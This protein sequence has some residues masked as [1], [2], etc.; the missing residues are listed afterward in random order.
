MGILST[1][2]E[3]RASSYAGGHVSDHEAMR[4]VFSWT[5]TAAGIDIDEFRAMGLSAYYAAIRNISED[6]A[7]L[8]IGVYRRE[9]NRRVE[10]PNHPLS[11]LLNHAPNDEA[12]A[13]TFRQSGTVG[14]LGWGRGL[15][16]IEWANN[17][18]PMNLWSIHPRDVSIDREKTGRKR[19][20]FLVNSELAGGKTVALYNEDVIHIPGMSLGGVVGCSVVHYARESLALS[21]AAENFGAGF[22]GSGG[23]ITLLFKLLK[24]LQDDGKRLKETWGDAHKPGAKNRGIGV[25]PPGV[26]IEKIGIPPEDSQFLQTRQFQIVEIARWFRMPPH[27]LMDLTRG[28]FSNIEHQSQEYVGDC[29]MPWII[30]WEQELSRKFLPAGGD[31]YVKHNVSAMLRGDTESRARAHAIGI[32]WGWRNPDEVRALE[33]ENPLPDG[34]GEPYMRPVNMVP[35]EKF[36]EETP[37]GDKPPPPPANPNEGEQNRSLKLLI[38]SYRS[39]LHDAISRAMKVEVDRI[40][41]NAKRASF[42]EWVDEFYAEQRDSFRGLVFPV[43]EALASVAAA[44]GSPG[45]NPADLAGGIVD[46]HIAE[47]RARLAAAN[48]HESIA[49][50]LRGWDS[51]ADSAAS[52]ELNRIIEEIGAE[53]RRQERRA[54]R[55]EQE[56]QAEQQAKEGTP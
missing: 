10:L 44:A 19:L 12:T 38:T 31:L 23:M 13:F 25:V 27:K 3:A 24:P 4:R 15:S 20:V 40:G 45:V 2:A 14:A 26:E 6:I 53:E 46:R 51:R 16:E 18:R 54:D 39:V 34:Q 36:G 35:A 49:Q 8:P 43:A 41:R 22:F 9:G 48:D 5:P 52:A 30:R 55:R 17:N 42:A 37:A 29:L 21:A 32:Q 1:I 50:E 11:M 33:D 7:K 56:Q 47:S 28:T